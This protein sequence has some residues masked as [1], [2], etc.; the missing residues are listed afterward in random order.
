MQ[1]N[2]DSHGG[3]SLLLVIHSIT[4]HEYAVTEALFIRSELHRWGEVLLQLDLSID[5]VVF[6]TL[7]TQ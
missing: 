6:D 5:K 7:I 4:V 1:T 2:V 3:S